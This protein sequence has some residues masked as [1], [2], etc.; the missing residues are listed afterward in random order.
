M[1]I[2]ILSIQQMYETPNEH[3]TIGPAPYNEDPEKKGG[4]QTIALLECDTYAHQL[5]RKYGPPPSGA[6]FFIAS[7][8]HSSGTSHELAIFYKYE[9]YDACSYARRVRQGAAYWDQDAVIA[10]AKQNHPI[11]HH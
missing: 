1:Q 6:Y 2:P 4:R 9:D 7:S 3:L 11:F 5:V 10:L 8:P